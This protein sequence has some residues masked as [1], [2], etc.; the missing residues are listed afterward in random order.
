[1][2]SH[3]LQE[4]LR[5]VSSYC[6]LLARRYKGKIDQDADEFIQFAVDG[7]ARMKGLIDG[8]LMYARVGRQEK[9]LVLVDAGE[10]MQAALANLEIAVKETRASIV[11]EALPQMLADPVQL[12][13]VF[14]NLIGNALK[15]RGNGRPV[16]HVAA[17]NP[18]ER[19]NAPKWIFSIQD[20]GI[21]FEPQFQERVFEIFQRLHTRE[22]YAGNGMGL[23]IT[24][25]SSNAMVALSG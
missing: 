17:R 13:Q 23:A 9:L 14:Q 20:N 10:S 3:D 1:M 2:T 12:A 21:G 15:F 25:K 16:I 11:C 7:A 5:M 8:L 4:P 18:G 24:K 6:G 19:G 22:K